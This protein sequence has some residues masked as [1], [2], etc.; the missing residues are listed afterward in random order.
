MKK[1]SL[2]LALLLGSSLALSLNVEPARANFMTN[3]YNSLFWTL[4]PGGQMIRSNASSD[5]KPEPVRTEVQ[6][7]PTFENDE[8]CLYLVL[9]LI[10]GF[11]L[12]ILWKA[13]DK[14]VEEMQKAEK[15]RN[16]HRGMN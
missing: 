13:E 1:V 11:I 5:D 10:G 2:V 12:R 9:T 15:E 7:K 4:G 3:P 14:R 6:S 8:I 16:W